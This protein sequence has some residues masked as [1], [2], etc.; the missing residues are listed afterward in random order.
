MVSNYQASVRLSVANMAYFLC[1]G[2]RGAARDD[3]QFQRVMATIDDIM[4]F[5]TQASFADTFPWATTI[6]SVKVKFIR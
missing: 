4:T 1:F 2:E 3:A 5:A 6:P